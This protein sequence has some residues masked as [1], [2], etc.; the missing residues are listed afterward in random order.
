MPVTDETILFANAPRVDQHSFDLVLGSGELR[1]LAFLVYEYGKDTLFD[2]IDYE[3]VRLSVRQLIGDY[4]SHVDVSTAP[5]WSNGRVEIPVTSAD[6]TAEVGTFLATVSAYDGTNWIVLG[7]G[8]VS[9][10]EIAGM[11]PDPTPPE[12]PFSALYSTY[13][14]GVD[15][16]ANGFDNLDWPMLTQP[17]SFVGW[18]R[19]N[20]ISHRR[21]LFGKG[22]NINDGW[23]IRSSGKNLEFFYSISSGNQYR[24]ETVND[25]FTATG[26]W[27]HVVLTIAGKGVNDIA[28]YIDSAP[29]SWN[30]MESGITGAVDTTAP[31]FLG[32]YG[33]NG[34]VDNFSGYMDE[35]AIFDRVLTPVE[36][37]AIYNARQPKDLTPLQPAHWWRMGERIK[38][39]L[40]SFPI[41][42]DVGL[43]GGVDLVLTNMAV[44]NIE[45]ETP[46]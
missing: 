25:A 23:F 11:P 46:W 17:R 27:Y 2:L 41:I 5:S 28:A 30:R 19:F 44:T 31:F 42:D 40:Q 10:K 29:V 18:F 6:I 45:E 37:V 34:L 24:G 32:G 4:E 7:N 9:T 33:N 36:V 3:V 26:Q 15:E 21:T 16:T 22:I 14:N 35:V 39:G 20:S 13:F 43:V 8:I 1:T 12:P 38:S